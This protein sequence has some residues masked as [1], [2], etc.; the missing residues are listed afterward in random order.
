VA[1]PDIHNTF[2]GLGSSPSN[3]QTEKAR[4]KEKTE[5]AIGE[6]VR[7]RSLHEPGKQLL[8]S[9]MQPVNG[10]TYNKS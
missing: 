6:N 5:K 8:N 9:Q 2:P 1:Y 10:H 7:V 3:D 4:K